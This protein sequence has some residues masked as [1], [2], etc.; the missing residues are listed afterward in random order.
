M[1]RILFLGPTHLG[2]A[3][4]A[5]G[6]ID[7]LSRTD[8][9]A[10]ITLVCGRLAA[11]ILANTPGV[12]RVI[13]FTK[14]RF[15]RH[16]LDIWRQCV[17]TRWDWVIDLRASG[18]GYMLLA[19]R[20]SV[21]APKAER[22]GHRTARW[23][24]VMGLAELPRPRLHATAEQQAT[25]DALVPDGGPVIA[26]APRA[27]WIGKIWPIERFA[28]LAERLTAASGPFPDARIAV[29]GGP[30]ERDAVLPLLESIPESRR[31]DLVGRIDLM[32]AYAALTRCAL[33]VGNDSGLLY[34]S[35]AADIPAVALV[36]PSLTLFGPEQPPLVAPWARKVAV[37]RT[38]TTYDEFVSAEGYDHRRT[39]SL[40]GTLEVDAVEA[41]TL[42]LLARLAQPDR[43]VHAGR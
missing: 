4:V 2:D 18:I 13:V 21:Y 10:R 23:A 7:H 34:L 31:I 28:A 40:M 43:P 14:R 12:E 26:L 35:V 41:V 36:G 24:H 5:S 19:R 16:W 33:F 38:P 9:G 37:A 1:S 29:F 25:A 32:T 8:P 15:H 30:G 39:G 27:A 42:A 6:L 3:A 17:G 22:H 11:P 20:R